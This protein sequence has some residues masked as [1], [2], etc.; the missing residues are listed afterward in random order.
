MRPQRIKTLW[1]R[2]EH[3]GQIL[4]GAKKVEVRAGYDNIRRLRAGD[5]LRL[6]DQYRYRIVRMA[7]YSSFETML[8]VEDSETIAPGLS[9][10]ELLTSCR[11][12][13]PPDREALGVVALE[14]EPLCATQEE[15]SRP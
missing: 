9:G 5:E 10:T 1:V 12:I 4:A 3:L 15:E 14:I 6:N 2:P 11:Q 8:D 7:H 13:Y